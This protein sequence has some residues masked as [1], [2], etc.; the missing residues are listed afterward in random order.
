MDKRN[1]PDTYIIKWWMPKTTIEQGIAKVFDD[2]KKDY[3][4]I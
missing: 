1:Q 4:S 2:M 3:A